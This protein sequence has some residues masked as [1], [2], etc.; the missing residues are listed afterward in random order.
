MEVG[1]SAPRYQEMAL[2]YPQ[3]Q[4]L[5]SN[6]CEYF[7]VVVHLCH[8]MVKFTKQSMFQQLRTFLSDQDMKN[9]HEEFERWANC[10][11]E[12]VN[13]AMNRSIGEQ[14]F[15]LQAIMKS[16]HSRKA[17]QLEK[18]RIRV[19]NHISTY[20]FQTTWKEIRKAGNTA[21]I[22]Q[23]PQ[24]VAW[25]LAKESS[26]LVCRGK[27][28]SGKSVLLANIV[29]D[30][31]LSIVSA[32]WPVAYFFCR[33]D[34][35]ESLKAQTI[36][37]SLLWQLLHRIQDLVTLEQIINTPTALD[38]ENEEVHTILEK[39]LPPGF[40]AYVVLDGVDECDSRETE[41]LFRLLRVLQNMFCLRLCVSLRIEADSSHEPHISQ[42]AQP[43]I[44]QIPEDN[45]DIVDFIYDELTRRIKSKKLTLGNPALILEISQSLL[46]RA[47]GMFLWVVM[48]IEALCHEKTDESILEALANL[49]RD[50][51][52]T[53]SRILS[54]AGML[55]EEYQKLTLKLVIAA[56]RPLVSLASCDYYSKM[57]LK[58]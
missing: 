21:I 17:R 12:E 52:E 47:Q 40:E 27:L 2:L 56:R 3:S 37:G 22:H 35:H 49:P 5:Q 14:G 44:L 13:L 1:R 41:A 6:V 31:N 58:C 23:L 33:H 39:T 26:T 19:L 24:Y 30:L 9:Y 15:R 57:G 38:L 42:L 53:F 55:G 50:L 7:I 45:S 46:Q 20:D 25:K 29:A 34:I 10:I 18:T 54:R 43:R 51:P 4:N 8:Q 11:K 32:R 48:Q 36:I 16:D 28:G